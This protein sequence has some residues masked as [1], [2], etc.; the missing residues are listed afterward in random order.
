MHLNKKDKDRQ[1]YAET[2]LAMSENVS[3]SSTTKRLLTTFHRLKA[4]RRY[5]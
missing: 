2:K 5:C 1:N 3:I 4:M